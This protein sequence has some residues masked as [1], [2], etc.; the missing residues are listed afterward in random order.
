MAPK[1]E[2]PFKIT[3]VIGPVT[4]QLKLPL[5]WKI[6]NMFHVTLLQPYKENEKTYEANFLKPPPEL[7]EGDELYKVRTILGHRRRGQGH[8]YY[9]KWKGYPISEASWEPEQVFSDDGNLLMHYK[10]CHQL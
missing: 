7:V 4:Y 9:V 1:R 10:E 2:G 5:S 6:N 3:K 8:Q